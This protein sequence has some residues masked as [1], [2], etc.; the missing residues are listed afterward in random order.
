[1]SNLLSAP[2]QAIKQQAF[3]QTP[4]FNSDCIIIL[5][6]AQVNEKCWFF[7]R[8]TVQEK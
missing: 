4:S 2:Y 5:R 1:M 3:I 8:K 6:S 7:C